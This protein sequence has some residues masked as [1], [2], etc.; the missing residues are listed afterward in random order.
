MSYCSSA[1]LFLALAAGLTGCTGSAGKPQ[2]TPAASPTEKPVYKKPV[3]MN[4]RGKIGALSLEEFYTLHESGQAV[5][6]DARPSVFYTLG[7]IPGAK[8]L[9]LHGSDEKIAAQE[10]EI[11]AAL[12]AG[13]TLVVYCS[14]FTCPDA[15]SLAIHFSGF[16]HPVKIFSGGWNAWKDAGMP[17]E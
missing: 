2:P 3:R 6:Y 8:S 5:V 12:A 7:H 9:P 1:F 15:R 10:A 11:K 16:G 4:G 17:T 13:K 14:S